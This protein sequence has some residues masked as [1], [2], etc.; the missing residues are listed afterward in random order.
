MKSDG[1]EDILKWMEAMCKIQKEQIDIAE[2][3]V[4]NSIKNCCCNSTQSI[5]DDAKIEVKLAQ[6]RLDAYVQIKQGIEKYMKKLRY[7]GE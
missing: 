2:R 1:V 4:E 5:I 7:C 6:E 3:N